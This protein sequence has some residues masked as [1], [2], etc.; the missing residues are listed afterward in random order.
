MDMTYLIRF[1]LKNKVNRY[2]FSFLSK[3]GKDGKSVLEDIF[4]LY[5]SG[6]GCLPFSRKLKV[7]PSYLFFEMGRIVF[8]QTREDVKKEL[9]SRTFQKGISLTARSVAHYGLTSPQKFIAPP[10]VVWNFTNVC[11]LKCKHCYQSAGKKLPHE[12]SL[13]KRLD[14]I[15]QLAREDVISIAFSGGEPLM[16]KDI[17]KVIKRAKENFMYVSVATNGT[18]ITPK[19]AKRLSDAGVDYV[20]ISLDSVNPEK[21]DEF[22]GVK[23]AWDKAVTGIK[24][25]V[26]E[27][28]YQVGLASTITRINFDELEELMNFAIELKVDKFFAFNFIPVGEGKNLI[29]IDLTPEQREKM[30]NTLYDYYIKERMV[31][32]TTCPQYARVCMM[33]SKGQLAPTSHCTI[34]KGEK[35][36]LMAEFLGGCGVGRAYCAIQPDGIVT[37]CVYMPIVVGDLKKQS[38]KEIW[39]TSK[40]LEELRSREDLKEHCGICEYRSACGGCRARAYAYF[41]DYKAPDPGCIN[42]K[43]AFLQLKELKEEVAVT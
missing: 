37:P 5:V 40:V 27:R 30:L 20:E 32:L 14:V 8:G 33:K 29:D 7:F 22:R 6:N 17:W 13:E 11:N 21:H 34:N 24:N 23:G 3:K 38:F 28:T 26:A 35:T 4:S 41:G 42:N 16:D 43:D 12:L 19:V 9:S 18:L 39:T 10:V 2:V 15:N 31:T 25:A 1:Y 36:R